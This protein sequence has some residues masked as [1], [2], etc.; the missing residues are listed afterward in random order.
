MAVFCDSPDHHKAFVWI[1]IPVKEV[2]LPLFIHQNKL[3]VK[4]GRITTPY[5]YEKKIGRRNEFIEIGL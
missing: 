3:Q 2:G 5:V 4:K 1:K